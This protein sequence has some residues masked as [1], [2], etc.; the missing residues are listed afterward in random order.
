M[1]M[2]W[3]LNSCRGHCENASLL[4]SGVLPEAERI[5]LLDHLSRCAS[6][7][8]YYEEMAKLSGEIQQWAL[9]EPPAEVST[10]FRARWMR[11]IQTADDASET[12]L[13]T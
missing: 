11:A 8:Q 2:K 13:A 7:R 5:S 6:C 4:A 1:N 10:A 3:Q 12:S 9:T